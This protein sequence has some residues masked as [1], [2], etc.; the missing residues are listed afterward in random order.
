MSGKDIRDL[1]QTEQV[2]FHTMRKVQRDR[3]EH[4]KAMSFSVGQKQ[5]DHKRKNAV[6]MAKEIVLEEVLT[7]SGLWERYRSWAWGK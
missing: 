1:T 3:M 7:E 5:E 4:T 2:L 6:A